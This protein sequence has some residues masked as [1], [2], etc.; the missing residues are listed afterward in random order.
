MQRRR[1]RLLLGGG[2]AA[3]LCLSSLGLWRAGAFG[4]TRRPWNGAVARTVQGHMLVVATGDWPAVMGAQHELARI[5]PDTAR[6]LMR[7]LHD[8]SARVRMAAASVLG[9]V[10]DESV[11]GSLAARL[12]DEHPLVRR[13]AVLAL[14][15]LAS[16]RALV[17]LRR[18]AS[19]SNAATRAAVAMALGDVYEADNVPVL[20]RMLEDADPA[21][22]HMA[23]MSLGLNDNPEV[24]PALVDMLDDARLRPRQAAALALARLSGLPA[25]YDQSLWLAWWALHHT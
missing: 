11:V 24:V 21:V 19:D 10:G 25:H 3:V 17:A 6:P 4:A 16:R 18:C 9:H 20:V 2:V 1:V 15:R 5:G 7:Y 13:A 22:R 14:H 23:A 8:P 12:E